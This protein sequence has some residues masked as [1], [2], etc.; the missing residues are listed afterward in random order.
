MSTKVKVFSSFIILHF[1]Y[2][3]ETWPL[4]QAQGDRL[5]TAY[6]S[7]LRRILGVGIAI[8]HSFEHLKGKC[9]VLSLRWFLA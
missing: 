1:V 8:C 7:C 4:T 3:S 6:N 5:E 9:Q 2:G